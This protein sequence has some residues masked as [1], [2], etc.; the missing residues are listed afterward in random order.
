MDGENTMIPKPFERLTIPL[1]DLADAFA[2][3]RDYAAPHRELE[4]QMK[5]YNGNLDIR[6]Y[7]NMSFDRFSLVPPHTCT[8]PMST[9][10]LGET[11]R[12]KGAYSSPCAMKIN[13]LEELTDTMSVVYSV[14]H[15]KYVDDFQTHDVSPELYNS[16]LTKAIARVLVGLGYSNASVGMTETLQGIDY[17]VMP[18]IGPK[19]QEGVIF[20]DP[21]HNIVEDEVPTGLYLRFGRNWTFTVNEYDLTPHTVKAIVEKDGKEVYGNHSRSQFLQQ[22]YSN[23]LELP[24]Q[25]RK[26]TKP[27]PQK[28]LVKP[29]SKPWWHLW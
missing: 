8:H 2:T 15:F 23:V 24:S 25:A 6:K 29:S 26:Y 14:A 28:D 10:S 1:R 3:E 11:E 4:L 19:G 5:Q 27:T 12:Q 22:A 18:F 16:I 13:S 9:I 17:V 20:V 7:V 21:T